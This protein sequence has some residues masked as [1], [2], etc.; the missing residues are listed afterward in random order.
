[1]AGVSDSRGPEAPVRMRRLRQAATPGTRALI[2]L[3]AAFGV[4]HETVGFVAPMTQRVQID[5]LS[6]EG[7]FV[8]AA[9]LAKRCVI[10]LSYA[11]GVAEPTSIHV[12]TYKT[13]TLPEPEITQLVRDIFPLTPDGILK[14]LKLR[15]PIFSPT[16]SHGHFGRKPGK[17]KVNG[18]SY[19]TFTWEK[20]DLAAKIKKAAG[21]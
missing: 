15:N 20:T 2:A 8:V 21:I 3:V 16:A 17:V 12:D 18:K 9:G 1:M 14:H 10:Q 5:L 11:I 7:W 19:E 13:G 6:F 4:L